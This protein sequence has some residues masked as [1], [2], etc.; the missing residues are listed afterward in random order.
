MGNRCLLRGRSVLGRAAVVLAVTLATAAGARAA[1]EVYVSNYTTATINVYSR[2]AT[3]DTAPL[4]T[5]QT[6][7]DRPHT[8]GMDI[9][10]HELF[11]TNNRYANPPD[12]AHVP[13]VMVYDLSASYP[14]NDAPKRSISGPATGLTKPAGLYVDMVHQELYVSNDL[15]SGSSVT[16]YPLSASGNVSPIRSLSG[17]T[18]G[19]EGPIG[20]A[21]DQIH[22]ELI[23]ASYKVPFGGSIS[24][25]ARTATGD[26][27]P[28]RTIQGASTGFNMPLGVAL[29]LNHDEIIVANSAYMSVLPGNILVFA[30]ASAGDVAPIR[31]IDG[32]S[33]H[34]CNPCGLVLDVAND[35]IVAAN[36][37][38]GNGPCGETV[39]VH[40]RG[41]AGDAAPSR[42]L[43]PGP[44]SEIQYPPSV[45]VVSRVACSDPA[46]PDGTPCDDGNLCTQ[47]DQCL[48]GACVGSNPVACTAADPCH[49]AG[50]CEPASG[51]C[52]NPAMADGT[53]CDDGNSCTG[54]D[55]CSAGI[56]VPGLPVLPA[57][58]GGVTVD[59][60]A[61]ATVAWTPVPGGAAYDVASST[62]SDLSINGTATASCL[63]SAGPDASYVDTRGPLADDGYY[64]LVRAQNGCGEG[65]YGA[66]P[67]G[68]PRLIASCP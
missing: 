41:V 48:S 13:A 39:T 27:A 63:L 34:L 35:E 59:G 65:S 61:S 36:S 22:D 20:L 58:V 1:D 18:T 49:A 55:A 19:I 11:V 54:G 50:T 6:G 5:I 2:T 21:V 23:V 38:F 40:A 47:T 32:P 4:R 67:D 56:C 64:Y 8:M 44:V 60:H 29:D 52:S 53:L 25:F 28:L 62:L 10:H 43:G 15:D 33:T 30:R 17:P 57:E 66:G 42:V 68:T 46:N 51:L 37:D 14:F 16:V 26:A 12:P 9:A 24:F 31:T 7:L 45:L 3:G